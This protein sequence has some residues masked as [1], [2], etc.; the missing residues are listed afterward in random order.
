MNEPSNDSAYFLIDC[1]A[2]EHCV[3][4]ALILGLH[5]MLYKYNALDEPMPIFTA[6]RRTLVSTETGILHEFLTNDNGL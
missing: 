3:D 4:G 5:N 2:T 1:G 6:G